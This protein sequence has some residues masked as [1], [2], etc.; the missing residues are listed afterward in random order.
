MDLQEATYAMARLLVDEKKFYMEHLEVYKEEEPEDPKE[1]AVYRGKMREFDWQR[2]NTREFG[3]KLA[4]YP[5]FFDVM[6]SWH[7]Y[8][9]GREGASKESMQAAFKTDDVDDL[10]DRASSL[11]ASIKT[12]VRNSGY[13]I[14]DMGA[15]TN[16]WDIAVRCSEKKS[17]VI[18]TDL[19]QRFNV[20]L[21]MGLIHISRRFAGHTLPGLTSWEDAERVLRMYGKD[22]LPSDGAP[23]IFL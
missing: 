2:A 3:N 7:V 19:H 23:F 16:G 22:D 9:L 6:E 14:C 11:A 4:A 1:R 18:C 5:N 10:I 20:A 15:G 17:R 13:V 8:V 21:E 12:Y